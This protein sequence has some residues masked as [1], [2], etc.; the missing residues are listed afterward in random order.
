M[1]SIHGLQTSIGP[2]QGQETTKRPPRLNLRE[3]RAEHRR[4]VA[5]PAHGECKRN[6]PASKVGLP[7]GAD[8]T[9]DSRGRGAERSAGSPSRA[10]SDRADPQPASCVRLEPLAPGCPP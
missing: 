2:S 8:K 9:S 3:V 1:I 4:E 6:W 7:P 5:A 10:R